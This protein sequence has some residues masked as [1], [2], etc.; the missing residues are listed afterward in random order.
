MSGILTDEGEAV[1]LD[2]LLRQSSADRGVGLQLGLFT[3]ASVGEVTTLA[4]ISEPTGGGYARRTLTDAGWT[5][6]GSGASHATQVFTAT[7]T[8]MAGL[9]RG[10]FLATTGVTP[11]LLLLEVDPAIPGGFS[12]RVADTYTITPTVTAA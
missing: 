12:L 9:I 8:D 7:G 10:Y 4:Q 3:N 6:T 1:L 2:V 5:R 11:R